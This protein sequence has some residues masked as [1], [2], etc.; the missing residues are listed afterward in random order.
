MV[1][2]FLALLRK[3]IVGN[4]VFTYK[5]RTAFFQNMRLILIPEIADGGE[6]GIGSGPAKSAQRP[7]L[8]ILPQLEQK[9]DVLHFSVSGGDPLEGLL[10]QPTDL[11]KMV[12]FQRVRELSAGESVDSA[13]IETARRR[14]QSDVQ[15]LRE[16]LG[17]QPAA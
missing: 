13:G 3:Y 10:D 2:S 15:E 17:S 1:A 6:Y 4:Q 12:A 7:E 5:G 11:E 9:V 14:I 8:D 16:L